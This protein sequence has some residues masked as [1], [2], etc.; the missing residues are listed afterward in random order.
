MFVRPVK[1]FDRT[2]STAPDKSITH[3]AVMFNAAAEGEAVVE[4]ALL[5]GDCRSTISCMTRLGAR[6]E[7]SG[8]TVRVRGGKAPVVPART[9][10]PI[11]VAKILPLAR[12]LTKLSAAAPI[13]EG[14]T[15][16]ESLLGERIISTS[17]VEKEGI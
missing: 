16:F 2:L 11:A 8:G 15:L 5:G 1:V 6:I 17:S 7:V 3:R 12:L 9:A 14:Q 13:K 10:R 4:N